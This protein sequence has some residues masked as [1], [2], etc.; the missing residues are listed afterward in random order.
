MQVRL[1]RVALGFHVAREV[2]QLAAERKG[3][4]GLQN[5]PRQAASF[6]YT[7]NQ[8]RRHGQ[9][10]EGRSRERKH[11]LS[12]RDDC[13]HAVGSF[14]HSSAL[15]SGQA[16]DVGVGAYG[17]VTRGKVVPNTLLFGAYREASR[18]MKCGEALN[19]LPRTGTVGYNTVCLN[20]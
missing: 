15:L 17:H 8:N 10:N 2:P 6:A 5:P 18:V 12:T 19:N 1:Q 13:A 9:L 7:Y 3:G 4:L 20:R 16:I 11:P 14:K